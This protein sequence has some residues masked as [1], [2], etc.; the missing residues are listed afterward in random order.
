MSV[1]LFHFHG[2]LPLRVSPTHLMWLSTYFKNLLLTRRQS[3]S[4]KYKYVSKEDEAGS[5]IPLICESHLLAQVLSI[6]RPGD[7]S[8][9]CCSFSWHCC[10]T[11]K[12]GST[13]TGPD[14]DPDPARSPV[15]SARHPRSGRVAT[16][17]GHNEGDARCLR[18]HKLVFTWHG[19]L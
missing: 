8:A 16:Q 2:L 18:C 13:P 4:T 10:T 5:L 15:A 17:H 9:V 11:W 6:P 19:R 1:V 7:S 3:P 12:E 14:P